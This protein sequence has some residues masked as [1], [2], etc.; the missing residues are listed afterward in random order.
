MLPRM[1]GRLPPVEPAPCC[2]SGLIFEVFEL[3]FRYLSVVRHHFDGEHIPHF[4]AGAV[5]VASLLVAIHPVQRVHQPVGPVGDA[6]RTLA[7]EF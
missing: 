7:E 2:L 6:P 5:E 1:M 3:A 4:L